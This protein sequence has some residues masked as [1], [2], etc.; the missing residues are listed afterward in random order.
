MI[1]VIERHT[2]IF[3]ES[4]KATD[5][6]GVRKVLQS[7]GFFTPEEIYCAMC[8]IYETFGSSFEAYYFL[9]AEEADRVVGYICFNRITTTIGSYELLWMA[10]HN[11]CRGQGLGKQLLNR[12]EG[13]VRKLGGKRLFLETHSVPLYIPTRKFYEKCKYQQ[14]GVLKNMYDVNDDSIV[15]VKEL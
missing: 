3:R 9:I 2:V 15:Y 5:E 14:I 7:S 6:E 1:E 11:D 8:P 13:A 4:L 12:V 10:V